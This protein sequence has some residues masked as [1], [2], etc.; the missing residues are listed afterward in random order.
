MR[1]PSAFGSL[2][3]QSGPQGGDYEAFA[4]RSA[5][6]AYDARG[7]GLSSRG[8]PSSTDVASFVLGLECAVERTQTGRFILF[9]P[10]IAGAVA[11]DN[12]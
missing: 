12:D 11:N 8:L 7:Q 3:W 1:T 4:K 10:V 9:G 6:T 2:R 5:V